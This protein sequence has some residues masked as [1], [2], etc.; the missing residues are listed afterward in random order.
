MVLA[1]AFADPL[2]E[3]ANGVADRETFARSTLKPANRGDVLIG[4]QPL[5]PRQPP[6]LREA[7]SPFPG[8][9][10]GWTKSRALFDGGRVVARPI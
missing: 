9:E 10:R 3:Q 4:V 5:I 1:D 8:P 2:P 6:W 7:V